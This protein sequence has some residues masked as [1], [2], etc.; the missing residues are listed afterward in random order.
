MPVLF[1]H[2]T[3]VTSVAPA[4][5]PRLVVCFCAQW[6]DTCRAYLPVLEALSEKYPDDCFAWVDIEDHP[7]FLGD[8]DVENFPTLLI[9]EGER[10]A[11]FGTMLPHIGH[12]DR[13]LA[14]L[15]AETAVSHELPDVRALLQ[16]A[17][18]AR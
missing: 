18:T 6:C 10:T 9:M 12:L 13:L 7:E 15:P 8:V 4:T 17:C 11:F 14:Q 1:P 16:E 3:A 5:A 2:S